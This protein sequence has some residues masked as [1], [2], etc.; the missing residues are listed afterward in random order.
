ML[1]EI[2][3]VSFTTIE[4]EP[5]AVGHV[6]AL[7]LH[8]KLYITQSIPRLALEV[9]YTLHGSTINISTLYRSVDQ[10]VKRRRPRCYT[11]THVSLEQLNALVKQHQGAVCV[12]GAPGLCSFDLQSNQNGAQFI[13]NFTGDALTFV[14]LNGLHV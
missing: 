9:F 6:Y 11:L 1:I 7:L 5:G 8:A 14:F 12:V 2:P 3:P 13:M 4:P 10:P